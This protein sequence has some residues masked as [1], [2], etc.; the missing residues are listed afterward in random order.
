VSS[1]RR[2]LLLALLG[3]MLLALLVGA[4]ATY[5]AEVQQADLLLDYHLRQIALALRDQ[6]FGGGPPPPPPPLRPDDNNFDYSIQVWNE[7]GVTLYYSYPQ[8]VFP[9]RAQLG[10]ATVHTAEGPWR[11]FAMQSR[12]E[13]IQVA[14]PMTRRDQL[15]AHAAWQSLRPFL[16]LVPIMSALIWVVVGRGLAPIARLASDIAARTPTA[17]DAVSEA[18]PAEVQPLV[19]ALNDLLARLHTALQ[20][21]RQL[22]A[23]A[24]HELRTPLAALLLQTQL[25]ERAEGEPARAAA[26]ADLRLGI[27]RATRVVQQLLTLAREEPAAAPAAPA[28]VALD[29][30]LESL[31]EEYRAL[32]DARCI[33]LTLSLAPQQPRDA[34]QPHDAQRPRIMGE[35]AS[36]R[37]L[38]A[39]LLDNALR[40]TP[41]GGVV[42]VSLRQQGARIVVAIEDTGPGIP[43]AERARVFDR[44]YRRAGVEQQGSGLGLA[45]VKAI[46]ERHGFGLS[47]DSAAS[48]GLVV[49]VEAAAAAAAAPTAATTVA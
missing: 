48:G 39:N 4:W 15:A 34:Q 40:Y 10:Y 23:D 24:A 29:A 19:R 41:A 8:H 13:I 28:P 2:N 45:I 3:A 43:A 32:A 14:Q 17:M 21:Q 16:L 26:L 33:G 47:L 35:A 1:I 46:A 36:L 7:D 37:T 12:A 31:V 18:V 20:A 6:G 42:N 25:V 9:N 49:R 27:E 30:L 5:R 22:V 11:V 38:F 44:F